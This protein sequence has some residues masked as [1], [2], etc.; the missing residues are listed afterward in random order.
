M[1]TLQNKATTVT[2]PLL[3]ACRWGFV[4]A[5]SFASDLSVSPFQGLEVVEDLRRIRFRASGPDPEAGEAREAGEA[6][7]EKL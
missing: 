4:D 5:V 6:A 2:K 3:L 7:A 1:Q